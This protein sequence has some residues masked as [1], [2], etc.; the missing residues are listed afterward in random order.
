MPQ[1][2]SFHVLFIIKVHLLTL[3]CSIHSAPQ[4]FCNQRSCHLPV[5]CPLKTPTSIQSSP[6]YWKLFASRNPAFHALS[7]A[8]PRPFAYVHGRLTLLDPFWIFICYIW[9]QYWLCLPPSSTTPT[10]YDLVLASALCSPVY[11]PW[12]IYWTVSEFAPHGPRTAPICST[13][14]AHSARV[15][16]PA[17]ARLQHRPRYRLRRLDS[18]LHQK[19]L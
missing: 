5:T 14:A 12:Y 6:D 1:S 15:T 2:I 18:R 10:D 19:L 4:P 9:P 8:L 16:A 17:P 11:D 3:L 13:A 7:P